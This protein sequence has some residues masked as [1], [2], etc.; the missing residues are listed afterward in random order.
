M[1]FGTRETGKFSMD[2]HAMSLSFSKAI[3]REKQ[4]GLIENIVSNQNPGNQF[5][6]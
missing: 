3:K 1:R 4:D 5:S 6:P 2:K